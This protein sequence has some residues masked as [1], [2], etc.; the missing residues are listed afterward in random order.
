M[1]TSSNPMRCQQCRSEVTQGSKFCPNCGE[2]TGVIRCTQCQ[3]ELAPD[4]KFCPECG[5]A[6]PELHPTQDV[7]ANS[8]PSE[9]EFYTLHDAAQTAMDAG[10]FERAIQNLDKAIEL[11]PQF[12]DAFCNRGLAYVNLG[13]YARA[14]QDFDKAIELKPQF[15]IAHNNKG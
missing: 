7:E 4:G 13:R 8:Y 2:P 10:D 5:V 9:Q 11:N 15:A 3:A 12:A 1:T 6:I 14:M